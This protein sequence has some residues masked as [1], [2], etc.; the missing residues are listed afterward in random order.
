MGEIYKKACDVN[1]NVG[2]YQMLKI[3]PHNVATTF[4]SSKCFTFYN[5]S[6]KMEIK[7]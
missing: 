1:M 6:L 7:K 5:Y 3:Y 2:N 4:Q